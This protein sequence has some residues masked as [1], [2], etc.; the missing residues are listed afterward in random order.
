[1]ILKIVKGNNGGIG[2]NVT[3]RQGVGGGGGGDD[4]DQ[5]E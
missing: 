3:G 4:L 2:V 5:T 1:M